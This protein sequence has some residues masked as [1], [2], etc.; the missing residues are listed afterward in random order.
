MSNYEALELFDLRQDGDRWEQELWSFT[1]ETFPA[2]QVFWR[3]YVVPLTNRINPAVS[4]STPEKIRLR[5]E[6]TGQ[7]E[8]M[9][10]HHY[11]VFYFLARA[12]K[13]ISEDKPL[14][15]PEDVF[16]L[17]DA[18]R[19]NILRFFQVIM[20]IY[21]FSNPCLGLPIT[22]DQL[23]GSC[24]AL[25]AVK[26]Y[27]NTILHFPVLGRSA[28]QDREFLPKREAL[29]KVR[30]SWRAAEKLKE[31]EFVDSHELYEHLYRDLAVFLE[32]NWREIINNLDENRES[33]K[34][35][36]IWKLESLLPITRLRAITL[37]GPLGPVASPVANVMINLSS[38]TTERK[39]N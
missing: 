28:N 12:R 7:L 33:S 37:R 34:F 24:P 4:A 23:C 31:N 20:D 26:E 32:R 29:P 9:T 39:E 22:E 38:S 21:T 13:R 25:G 11:S 19:D 30:N 2:Y 3:R 14:P 15:L 8:K 36:M 35:K 1:E 27:R 18:C 16:A 10:M 5:S 17:L 6:I